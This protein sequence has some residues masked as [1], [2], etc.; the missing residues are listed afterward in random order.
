MTFE[1]NSR[2]LSHARPHFKPV[3]RIPAGLVLFSGSNH[4]V[5]VFVGRLIARHALCRGS[6]QD[7]PVYDY[8]P[9]HPRLEWERIPFGGRTMAFV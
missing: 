1:H 6:E 5:D 2:E 9:F 4:L 8:P 3:A 7:A